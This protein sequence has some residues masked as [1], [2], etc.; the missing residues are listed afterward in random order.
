MLHVVPVKLDVQAQVKVVPE[1]VHVPF[2]F[3]FYK[4]TNIHMINFFYFKCLP[5]LRQGL[6]E[7]GF[8]A[9]GVLQID[10]VKAEVHWHPN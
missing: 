5:P 6:G 7:H 3:I 2:F 1:L 9:T 10:P 4:M 8:V